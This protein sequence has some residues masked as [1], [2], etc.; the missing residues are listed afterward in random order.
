MIRRPHRLQRAA[1]SLL[2]LVAAVAVSSL[3]PAR[4]DTYDP[5]YLPPEV[6][7]TFDAVSFQ[8]IRDRVTE[9][10]TERMVANPIDLGE[11][12]A[13]GEAG[14]GFGDES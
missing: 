3:R 1:L 6:V 2:F 4:A 13:P 7:A 11:H 10:F 9:M 12:E 8:E 5:S 14:E